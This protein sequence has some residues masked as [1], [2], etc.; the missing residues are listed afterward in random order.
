M[1]IQLDL[2]QVTAH[3]KKIRTEHGEENF[4]L[5]LKALVNGVMEKD[6]G[7]QYLERLVAELGVPVDLKALK[8]EL[9]QGRA[10]IPKTS[11]S[12]AEIVEAAIKQE[13][14]NCKTQA[15]FDL[16]LQSWEILKAYLNA[17][18]S[19]DLETAVKA[20]EGLNR[21]LDLAP[22]VAQAHQK[23]EESPEATTNRD[24]VDAPK[25][26]TEQ[27]NQERLLVQLSAIENLTQLNT[28]YKTCRPIMDGIVN[29][30]L[31]DQL[32][33]A[34]REKKKALAN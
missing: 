31:R 34:V 3:L 29:H 7:E 10:A 11:K 21:L 33:D 12:P 16:V 19:L 8:T 25:Q 6:G 20:R 5:A 23:L 30:K 26:V 9:L 27:S 18:F 24:Y 13:M 4:R 2:E 17:A 1:P 14:P 15:H 22:Q 32:F 28:W